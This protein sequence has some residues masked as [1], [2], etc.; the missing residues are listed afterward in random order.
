MILVTPVTAF[1]VYFTIRA[2][3][4]YGFIG[5][6]LAYATVIITTVEV[7]HIISYFHS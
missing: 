5:L 7:P 1:Y 4:T 6:L 3:S 2:L